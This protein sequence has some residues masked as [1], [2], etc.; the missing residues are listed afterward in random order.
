MPTADRISNERIPST[1]VARRPAPP[2]PPVKPLPAAVVRVLREGVATPAKQPPAARP[3][4]TP[5]ATPLNLGGQL[6]ATAATGTSKAPPIPASSSTWSF[7]PEAPTTPNLSSTTRRY[8]G[9]DVVITTTSQD[10]RSTS[11]AT[12]R[13]QDGTSTRSQIERQS[14]EGA[15]QDVVPPELAQWLDG[16]TIQDEQAEQGPVQIVRTQIQDIDRAGTRT[17]RSDITSYSQQISSTFGRS[18]DGLSSLRLPDPDDPAGEALPIEFDLQANDFA[19]LDAQRSGQTIT[20]ASGTVRTADGVDQSYLS[21][22]NE[23]GL[24]GTSAHGGGAASY[25]QSTNLTKLNG[26]VVS[27]SRVLEARN[28]FVDSD[29]DE[30]D[31]FISLKLHDD[32]RRVVSTGETFNYRRIEDSANGLLTTREFGDYDTTRQV[33]DTVTVVDGANG[34]PTSLSYQKVSEGG[35][36]V[37]TQTVF[38]GT[39]LSTV[40]DYR[41]WP[42]G[43]RTGS[44]ITK[45]GS[46]TIASSQEAIRTVQAG[47]LSAEQLGVDPAWWK[48]FLS[49]HSGELVRVESL[50]QN[51]L[52]GQESTAR[53]SVNAPGG[54]F[55]QLLSQES[56]EGNSSASF[57]RLGD[58]SQPGRVRLEQNGKIDSISQ[59]AD[60]T[61][62]INGI[63]EAGLEVANQAGEVVSLSRVLS[64]SRFSK[65]FDALNLGQAVTD[66]VQGEIS[67][68]N[69]SI[70]AASGSGLLTLAGRQLAGQV[71]GYAGVGLQA[72]DGV[73]D[74][75][76]G[77]LAE[78]AGNLLQAGGMGLVLAGFPAGWTVL[79]AMAAFQLLNGLTPDE[80]DIATAPLVI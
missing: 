13:N 28:L 14:V 41:S 1:P 74:L 24:V 27:D 76:Q 53:L 8:D 29:I 63:A 57:L 71:L 40:S 75:F 52:T 18:G 7:K 25:S 77:R 50:H 15:L 67:L 70:V 44:T 62:T 58:S 32:F 55:L 45:D 10:D 72:A 23:I 21:R 17:L 64:D 38:E 73:I 47:Q 4:S 34:Q 37:Q 31:E 69:T 65:V 36:R 68:E 22:T 78:G 30:Q 12:I 33:G 35:G 60:G 43:D 56:A 20:L 49:E 51:N 59:S 6:A 80:G 79:G 39:Q 48:Q 19:S 46:E 66:L 54:D 11:V 42:N 2:P 26:Q 3:A 16:Q 61:L 5:A 9:G